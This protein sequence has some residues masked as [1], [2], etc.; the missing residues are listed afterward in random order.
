MV[1]ST[2]GTISVVVA[3]M[4]VVGDYHDVPG[5]GMCIN[6]DR[7][8]AKMKMRMMMLQRLGLPFDQ[9][10]LWSFLIC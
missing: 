1:T 8:R 3:V 10:G 9:I 2:E 6:L 5:G 4:I 7:L